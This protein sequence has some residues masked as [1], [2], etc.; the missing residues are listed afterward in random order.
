MHSNNKAIKKIRILVVDD[1]DDIQKDFKL[2]FSSI[3]KATD[4]LDLLMEEV[5][6]ETQSEPLEMNYQFLLDTADQGQE[7]LEMV[8]IANQ[9]GKPY[10]VIF[11]DVRMPPGWNGVETIRKIWNQYPETDI[12]LCSA[13]SDFSWKEIIQALGYSHRLLVLKKPYDRLEVI[14]QTLSIVIKKE[15]ISR[16]RKRIKE[17]ENLSGEPETETAV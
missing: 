8:Q 10:T 15:E 3:A 13:Y 12:V 1:H 9:E 7:A 17:L 14:L 2:I 16:Y 6:E 5:L 11:M 4:D